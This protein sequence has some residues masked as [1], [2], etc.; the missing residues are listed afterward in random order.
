[1]NY[2]QN[3]KLYQMAV[4]KQQ[5]LLQ[6]GDLGADQRADRCAGGHR[7]RVAGYQAGADLSADRLIDNIRH[8]ASGDLVKRIEVEGA[9]EMGELADSLRRHMQSE[10]VRTVGDVHVGKRHLQ[11]RE[12]N[13]DGG[14]DL[15]PVLN[16]RP[17]RKKPQ[18]AWSS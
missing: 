4:G 16:S 18:P 3:D 8:I 9:N 14:N 13:R 5:Q 15:S 11:R 1:M 7:G 17:L 2:L 6:P 12:R 10:L